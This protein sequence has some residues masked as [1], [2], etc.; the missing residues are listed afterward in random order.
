M[1]A[2]SVGDEVRREQQEQGPRVCVRDSGCGHTGGCLGLGLGLGMQQHLFIARALA[3]EKFH[4][5]SSANVLVAEFTL[6]ARLLSVM[7]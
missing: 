2:A 6:V 4:S 7:T 1:Q 3:L 5:S